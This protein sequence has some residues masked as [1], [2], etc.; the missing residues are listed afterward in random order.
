MSD[1][2][3]KGITVGKMGFYDKRT[4]PKG[5]RL[6]SATYELDITGV[7]VSEWKNRTLRAARRAVDAIGLENTQYICITLDSKIL[8]YIGLSKLI[9][10]AIK[11]FPGIKFIYC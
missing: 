8:D 1:E 3:E 11:K 4:Y 6:S 10:K 7:P 2:I 9:E 5:K